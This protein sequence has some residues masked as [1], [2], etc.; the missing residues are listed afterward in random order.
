M[1]SL[2]P[3]NYFYFPLQQQYQ[4]Q[5]QSQPQL[6]A[7][8]QQQQQQL[9]HQSAMYDNAQMYQAQMAKQPT[10]YNSQ[11][12]SFL[13]NQGY[14]QNALPPQ[15]QQQQN[16]AQMPQMYANQQHYPYNKQNA[17]Q[18]NIRNQQPIKYRDK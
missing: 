15:Y 16:H 5:S 11:F 18:Q 9:F 4:S 17:N 6:Q 1:L 8:Q 10:S 2:Y 3:K 14:T 7:Q 13:A 12:D